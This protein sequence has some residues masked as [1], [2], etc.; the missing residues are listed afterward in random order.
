MLIEPGVRSTIRAYRIDGQG[1]LWS[2]AHGLF[3]GFPLDGTVVLTIRGETEKL[4]GHEMSGKQIISGNT[5]PPPTAGV[6][7]SELE[8]YGA[9]K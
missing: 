3:A 2:R 8:G 9:R 6:L 4:Y 7:L 5:P 1:A